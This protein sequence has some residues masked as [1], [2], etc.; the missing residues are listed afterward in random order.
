MANVSINGP[1][2]TLGAIF[3]V[4]VTTHP[5]WVRFEPTASTATRHVVDRQP[6][7]A[8]MLRR[9][10]ARKLNGRR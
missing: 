4:Q 9:D 3:G 5:P 6:A 8:A 2:Q 7:I 10:A 1:P